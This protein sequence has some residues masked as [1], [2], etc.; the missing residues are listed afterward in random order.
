MGFLQHY[1]VEVSADYSDPPPMHLHAADLP[2]IV[3]SE[4]AASENFAPSQGAPG[5]VAFSQRSD[6][7]RALRRLLTF[8]PL[9]TQPARAWRNQPVGHF[10]RDGLRTPDSPRVAACLHFNGISGGCGH[11]QPA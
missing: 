2:G 11:G 9:Q 10:R 1:Y 6:R 8:G 3:A 7:W 4:K 5:G